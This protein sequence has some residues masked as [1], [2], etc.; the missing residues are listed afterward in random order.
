MPALTSTQTATST[1]TE[2]ESEATAQEEATAPMEP[3]RSASLDS[4]Q[5][6][7]AAENQVAYAEAVKLQTMMAERQQRH[8]EAVEYYKAPGKKD[9]LMAAKFFSYADSPEY[10]LKEKWDTSSTR[11][12]DASDVSKNK[13]LLAGDKDKA[14]DRA[15]KSGNEKMGTVADTDI[16]ALLKASGNEKIAQLVKDASLR[17][18][19]ENF[20]AENEGSQDPE[21][22]A[23]AA[24]LAAADS[25][26]SANA[27]AT[28]LEKKPVETVVAA[29][30]TREKDG[31][32]NLN[33]EENQMA[34]GRL[35]ASMGGESAANEAP[36]GEGLFVR[37]HSAHKRSLE[38]G[39]VVRKLRRK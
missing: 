6:K 2:T 29:P 35:L 39:D 16:K 12:G 22:L 8:A 11:N 30:K 27:A 32:F 20:L 7:A 21:I 4:L 1:A 14:I 9:P 18:K 34:V 38:R 37:V 17:E 25:D 15:G 23:L 24:A 36:A 26:V 33:D 5:A 13:T 3:I 19:L 10:G 31:S 28:T